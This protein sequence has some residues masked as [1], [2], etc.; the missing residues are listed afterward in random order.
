VE[1]VVELISDV[2]EI[3][4]R[5]SFEIRRF[6][7]ISYDVVKQIPEELVSGES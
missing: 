5:G 6:M 1:K 3:H 2:I 4:S 7:S